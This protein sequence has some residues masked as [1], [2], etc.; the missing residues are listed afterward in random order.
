MQTDP[1]LEARLARFVEHH[2]LHGECLAI[3][4]LCEGRPDL[5]EP[6]K[7][8]VAEYLDLSAAMSSA[9]LKPRPTG[10]RSAE[11]R[12]RPISDGTPRN[13]AASPRPELVEGRSASGDVEAGRRPPDAGLESLPTFDGFRT[14]ERLG[15]GGMGE[16]YKLHD[17]KLDRLVAAKIVRRDQRATR[18]LREFLAEARTLAL[19]QDR[20][21]VQI[22]EF[23]DEAD[24]PVI[25]MEFVDGFELGQVAS[26][27]EYRQRARIIEQVA[28]AIHHAHRLGI[29]HRDL[30]PSNI[31]LDAALSP[32]I[33]DFGLSAGDP[34]RGHLR[35]TLPYLAP[36]QLDPAQPI[37][38]R[39]DVYA[40][41]V[42][43][44]EILCGDVPFG[45][46]SEEQV[47]DA[48]RQGRPR[49]PIEIEPGVPEPLQAIALKAMETDPAGRYQ[50]AQEMARDLWRFL[51][52]RPVLAR[53]AVYTSALD[54]RIKAHL[55]HVA[56]WLR[57]RLIY[58]HEAGHLRAAYRELEAREDDWILSSRTLS[59][60][61]IALYL[62]AF[63]LLAGALF[64]FNAYVQK[65]VAGIAKPFLVLG[66][67]FL[68]LNLIARYLYRREN[69][70]VAVA[71]Y[72]G[73][74]ALLPLFLMILLR[75]NHL[76]AVAKDTA[77]Q[78][79]GNGYLSNRQLQITMLAACTWALVLALRT[80]TAA[81]ST[82]FTGLLFLMGL[83]VLA[84]FGLRSWI[85]GWQYH[86]IA[87]HLAPLVLVYGALGYVFERSGRQW[88]GR[89]LYVAAALT[90]VA[91][92]E[93][94]AQN[95]K[96]LSYFGLDMQ[97]FRIQGPED[98]QLGNTLMAMT[99]NGVLMYLAALLVE[100]RGTDV[101]RRA[102]GLLFTLSPF[103]GLKPL[104]YLCMTGYYL[105]NFDWLY[106]A[107]S[108]GSCLLSHHRQRRSFYIAGL[109]NTG[110]ALYEI[111]DH[112]NWTDKPLWAIALVGGGLVVLGA[113][114]ALNVRE[115][116]RRQ[117]GGGWGR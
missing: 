81:L 102:G 82:V 113:G 15:R 62:G 116:N 95:G 76:F 93:L 108:I 67:P 92:V 115:R 59:Y 16:V 66:L 43:L 117:K 14:I 103:A 19:F 8:L 94:M 85:E 46:A 89:P 9:G 35:G 90:L 36:E 48:I 87:W 53:P 61:Q 68:G 4:S 30:K 24:P 7:K 88:F 13:S 41:G 40:L 109:M 65:V 26:S 21:I 55:D 44:Y 80:R 32:K 42:I 20:R 71:F 34:A 22:H 2:V 25:I 28:E 60:S 77:G 97:I 72:L 75:E 11:P 17:L 12:P 100:R 70:A 64:Y 1:E 56:E 99:V 50:S 69:R 111:A 5:I 27:L 51:D 98:T 18:A 110:W 49:L 78:V 105:R 38:A 112:N 37:D 84:D 106:L 114:Y 6:L 33:L 96:A 39:T 23:R 47:V 104:G 86:W 101:M 91:V 74:V 10:E 31:M 73:G 52:G 57:L 45:G 107:L 54:T 3:E 58:P 79:F 63:F 29:Q 83:A